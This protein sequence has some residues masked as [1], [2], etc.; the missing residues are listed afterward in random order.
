MLT[1]R[2]AVAGHAIKLT[3][4]FAEGRRRR[5]RNWLGRG[6]DYVRQG[7]PNLGLRLQAAFAQ[8]LGASDCRTVIVGADCPGLTP[9]IIHAAFDALSSHAL[10]LG[11]ATDGGYYLV[12]LSQPCPGLFDGIPWGTEAVLR[13]TLLRATQLGLNLHWLPPL[14]DANVP[15][16]LWTWETLRPASRRGLANSHDSTGRIS[17]VIP[18]LNEAANIARAI[19]SAQST[20]T[21]VIVADGG[22]IDATVETARACG[23]KVIQ[24]PRGR[25]RQMNAGARM[26]TGNVLLFL[27]ADS[28]LPLEC[29]EPIRDALADRRVAAG[30]FRL[31]IDADGVLVRCAET[32]AR[33]RSV[34]G[35][36]PR[37]NQALFMRADLFEAV[38]GYADM[39]VMEDDELV[40]RLR[41]R[42][43]IVTLELALL[44]SPRRWLTQGP[45]RAIAT[46]AMLS[47]AYRMGLS[48]TRLARIAG[49]TAGS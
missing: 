45:A 46:R 44:A 12:G 5:M 15:A 36:A 49:Q 41:R 23:A 4:C 39:P 11:P 40:R 43:R 35:Q 42:G 6:P 3:V 37:G 26:A 18:T 20:A 7:Q 25:A 31:A 47:G 30:A 16:D 14:T 38:G 33:W 1:C 21:E 48:D 22:S 2:A 28:Q 19:A 13:E 24:S 8:T 17:V 27:H 32:M 29:S 10:V 9:D 34:V